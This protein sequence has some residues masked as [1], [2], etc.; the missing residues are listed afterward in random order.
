[1]YF[2]IFIASFLAISGT[3]H[4]GG[5]C[6]YRAFLPLKQIRRLTNAILE[7]DCGSV[8]VHIVDQGSNNPAP[9]ILIFNYVRKP[10]CGGNCTSSTGTAK[11]R[12]RRGIDSYVL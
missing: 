10:Y 2:P 5:V 6:S 4:E 3:I 9:G 7:H 1:M 11:S 12:V 8:P